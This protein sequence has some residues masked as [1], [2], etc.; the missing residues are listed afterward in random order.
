ML[1]L[2]IAGILAAAIVIALFDLPKFETMQSRRKCEILYFS[3][4]SL[5]AV[6]SVVRIIVHSH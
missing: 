6:V 3:L 2:K 1:V 5:F 4:L